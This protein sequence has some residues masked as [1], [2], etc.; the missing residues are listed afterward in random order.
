MALELAGE[1]YA[2]LAVDLYNGAVAE[3]SDR[4]RE[5]RAL[6]EQAEATANLQ[7]AVGFLREHGAPKI[8]SLGWCFGGG[9]SLELARSGEELDATVIYY[10]SLVTEEAA[11]ADIDWPVLGIFGEADGS[12]PVATVDAFDM[13]L[14]NLGIRNEIY[15]YPG[16][17]HA[18]ANP[19]GASY[20]PAETMDA[21]EKTLAFLEGAL[22]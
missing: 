20:A 10:G 22:M 8:A 17:G 15:I 3:D 7:A 9:Q 21:W 18:F 19:S 5:L 16:V 2:V 14:D 13:A 4:A 12:I 1:G 6:L 11:L